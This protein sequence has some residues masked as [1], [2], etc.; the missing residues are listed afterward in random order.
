[1]HSQ[2]ILNNLQNYQQK[3]CKLENKNTHNLPKWKIE[4]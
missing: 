3:Q 1:M 4:N 2:E